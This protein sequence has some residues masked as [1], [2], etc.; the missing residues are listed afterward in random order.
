MQPPQ[1]QQQPCPPNQYIQRQRQQQTS[2]QFQSQQACIPQTPPLQI[3]TT[4]SIIN[5]MSNLYR[6]P[7]I[8]S[9]SAGSENDPRLSATEWLSKAST[10]PVSTT[11]AGMSGPPATPLS[12]NVTSPNSVRR[13]THDAQ[14]SL[15]SKDRAQKL[16]D[17]TSQVIDLTLDEPK[18]FPTESGPSKKRRRTDEP[19]DVFMEPATLK[20]IVLPVQPDQVSGSGVTERPQTSDKTQDTNIPM[21]I[22]D[23]EGQSLEGLQVVNTQ[24][25]AALIPDASDTCT[26]LLN[27]PEVAEF[28]EYTFVSRE[29]DL[30]QKPCTLCSMRH[31]DDPDAWPTLT[32]LI[33]PSIKEMVAHL[34]A[35]HGEVWTAVIQG[36]DEEELELP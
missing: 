31:E 25:E 21:T 8:S 27:N 3:N 15:D 16:P 32:I 7:V 35:I 5:S 20:D 22:C 33:N 26:D 28:L 10:S 4:S 12:N 24:L 17:V 30:S 18:P 11:Q 1:Q 14:P 6:S 19:E 29:D 34:S 9:L 2:P 23:D 13:M 36:I